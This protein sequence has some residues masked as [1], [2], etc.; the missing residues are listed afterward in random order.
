MYNDVDKGELGGTEAP[1]SVS[2]LQ[3]RVRCQNRLPS[4]K[5]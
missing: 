5:K 4:A 2:E 1:P 3:L